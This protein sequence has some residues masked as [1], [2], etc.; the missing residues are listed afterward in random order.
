MLTRVRFIHPS[1]PIEISS[2]PPPTA[3]SH[4]LRSPLSMHLKGW[5][6]T[7]EYYIY[8][9]NIYSNFNGLLFSYSFNL[10]YLFILVMR[11]NIMFCGFIS[12]FPFCWIIIIIICCMVFMNTHTHTNTHIRQIQASNMCYSFFGESDVWLWNALFCF[13][14]TKYKYHSHDSKSLVLPQFGGS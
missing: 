2:K 12:F 8:N 11:N 5:L 10:L 7:D 4:L 13:L 1:A 14:V 6:Q 9:M 3:P